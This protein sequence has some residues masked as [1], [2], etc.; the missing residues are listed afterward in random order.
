MNAI[1]AAVA[2]QRTDAVAA[3]VER[4][5]D[6]INVELT[7]LAAVDGDVNKLYE[8]PN[9]W[10]TREQ[11]RKLVALRGF[12][13]SITK[14]GDTS[15]S[16]V[17]YPGSPEIRVPSNRR[18]EEVLARTAE[19]ASLAFDAYI[20]KLTA[21]VGE[22]AAAEMNGHLWDYSIL[23]ITRADA[24]VERWKTQCIVN[25]SV[26]GKLFNQWPTRKMA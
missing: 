9:R 21:K 26:L 18:A 7:K 25:V 22:C 16:G 24:S 2:P 17:S 10:H 19:E 8:R 15:L 20:A 12:I 4:M 23:T 13:C 5:T 14:N 11:Y 6:H 1:E 3:A